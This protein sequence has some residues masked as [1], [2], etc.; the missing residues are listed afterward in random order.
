MTDRQTDRQTITQTDRHEFVY[1]RLDR[2][3]DKKNIILK[4]HLIS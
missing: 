3:V 4:D 2:K 1:F